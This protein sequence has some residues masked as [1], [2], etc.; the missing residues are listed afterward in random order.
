MRFEYPKGILQGSPTNIKG[1]T[2]FCICPSDYPKPHWSKQYWNNFP[3]EML[4]E[5]V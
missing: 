1:K 4:A 5:K 2:S 3:E